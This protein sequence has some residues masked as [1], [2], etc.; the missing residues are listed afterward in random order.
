L[1]TA[2]R[3]SSIPGTM[4]SP[5]PACRLVDGADGGLVERSSQAPGLLRGQHR[6]GS[7]RGDEHDYLVFDQHHQRPVPAERIDATYGPTGFSHRYDIGERK[8]RPKW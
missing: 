8:A 6:G 4:G 7:R 2:R 1:R 5:D 3:V